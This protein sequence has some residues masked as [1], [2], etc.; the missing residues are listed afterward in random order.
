MG[1]AD[2]ILGGSPDERPR[3]DP[4]DLQPVAELPGD[5]AELVE[6]LEAE[7]LF[8]RRDLKH[9]IGGR[10][11]D[12]L[13]RPHAL[14]A[15]ILD[16]RGARGVAVGENAGKPALSDHRFGQPAGEGGNRLRE[17][18]PV[19]IDRSAGKLPMAGRRVLAAG[20]LDSIAPLAARLGK[21]EERR[22]AAGR[23]LHRPAKPERLEAR[24]LQG[25]APQAVAIAAS[26][27]ASV[28]DVAQRIGALVAVGRRIL[29]AAAADRIED[30]ED[31]AGHW[32]FSGCP[33]HRPSA[34]P[35][36]PPLPGMGE[37]PTVARS[38]SLAIVRR[39]TGV[40]SNA[41]RRGRGPTRG[42]CRLHWLTTC[43]SVAS[44]AKAAANRARV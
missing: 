25:P 27:G 4:A 23:G 22:R 39:E 17:I 34:G 37:A 33:L 16:H 35:P 32:R 24:Q 28:G 3:D 18:A 44:L 38:S 11:A 5:A 6:A 31:G 10:V 21:G 9:R 12:G 2:E 43:G 1:R 20:G 14:L 26:L 19:E 7:R 15:V 36:P 40:L 30:D 8:V 41:L 42:S 13:P 29:G